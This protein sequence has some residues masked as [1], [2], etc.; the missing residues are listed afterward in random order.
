MR[1]ACPFCS[2]AYEVDP[3]M[4]PPGRAVRCAR[5]GHEWAPVAAIPAAAAPDEDAALPAPPS[6]AA[7]PAAREEPPAG[8][9][10]RAPETGSLR[11]DAPGRRRP[12]ERRGFSFAAGAAWLISLAVLVAL[13]WAAVHFRSSVERAW[14]PSQRAYMALGLG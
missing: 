4:V 8:M 13:G 11:A 7:A 14:P 6:R 12:A 10:E 9:R 3:A 2:A 5:C 1:I